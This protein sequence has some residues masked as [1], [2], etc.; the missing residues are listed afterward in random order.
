[1]SPPQAE[2][3]RTNCLDASLDLVIAL[4]LIVK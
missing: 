1:M 4:P 2:R 3:A